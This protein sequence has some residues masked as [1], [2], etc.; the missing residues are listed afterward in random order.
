VLFY[1][2]CFD[3]PLCVNGNSRSEL[4]LPDEA[5]HLPLNPV[6]SFMASAVDTPSHEM[7]FP[8][9]CLAV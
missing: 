2:C 1:S 5:A 8:N 4:C 3:H 7:G 9:L 6:E